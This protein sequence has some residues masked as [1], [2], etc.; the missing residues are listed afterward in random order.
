VNLLVRGP[1]GWGYASVTG[2]GRPIWEGAIPSEDVARCAGAV[3]IGLGLDPKRHATEEALREALAAQLDRARADAE[4]ARISQR[5]HRTEQQAE[6]L[7]G[8]RATLTTTE[9]ARP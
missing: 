7:R 6:R 3:L 9:R 8:L 4:A 1:R 5:I 2:G